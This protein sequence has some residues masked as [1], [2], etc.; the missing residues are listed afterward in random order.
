MSRPPS[1]ESIIRNTKR[2]IYEPVTPI[3]T[4]LIIPNYSGVKTADGKLK[5]DGSALTGV[6]SAPVGTITMFGGAA[7]PTGWL[8]CDHSSLLRAGT[9]AD[10][11]AVIGTTFGSADG[12]HFNVPDMSGIFP[13]GAGN[14]NLGGGGGMVKANGGAY[15]RGLGTY[16]TDKMQGHKHNLG[17]TAP[18]AGP[19]AGVWTASTGTTQEVTIST[20]TDGTN[21]TPRTGDETSPA[22]LGLS[23]IIKY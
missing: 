8:L 6:S 23:F 10:L 4:E 12:T 17:I 21:G 14:G 11:F 3:G 18:A 9:Y 15:A 13:V 5:G 16:Y 19:A 22:A 2:E 1:A 7:A 20:I